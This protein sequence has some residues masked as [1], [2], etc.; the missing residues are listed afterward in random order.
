MQLPNTN[1]A[2]VPEELNSLDF[3]PDGTVALSNSKTS[4]NF[5]F[6]VYGLTFQANTRLIE[7]GQV[8]QIAADIGSDPYTADG[9]DLRDSAHALIRAS[10]NIPACRLMIS[11]QKRIYCVG[12]AHL[13]EP[14]TPTTLIA[15]AAGLLLEVR[16]YLLVLRDILPKWP[17]DDS[18]APALQ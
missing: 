5:A 13:A 14:W 18:A 8:L 7:S 3:L 2:P 1:N 16:P 4:V 15:A 10:Q 11:R 12:R 6:R 9:A 17:A